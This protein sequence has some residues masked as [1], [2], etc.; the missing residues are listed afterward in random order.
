MFIVVALLPR[1]SDL[2]HYL[3][4]VAYTFG[5]TSFLQ[6]WAP[7]FLPMLPPDD[8]ASTA[9]SSFDMLLVGSES[10]WLVFKIDRSRT[11]SDSNC[12]AEGLTPYLT[13]SLAS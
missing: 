12:E 3:G 8:H 6:C 9:P 7:C 10:M 4:D 2:I 1:D 13:T 5:D 11:C